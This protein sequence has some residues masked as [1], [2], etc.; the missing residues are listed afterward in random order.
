MTTDKFDT[1][2]QR[3][4]E[5]VSSIGSI[6]LSSKDR[7]EPAGQPMRNADDRTQSGSW[8]IHLSIFCAY[9]APPIALLLPL[10]SLN[11]SLIAVAIT[12]LGVALF[13]AFGLDR[14][15]RL[16]RRHRRRLI[17]LGATIGLVFLYSVVKPLLGF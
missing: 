5:S 1:K 15:D 13:A 4:L 14:A 6:R 12:G 10:P 7:I 17:I 11:G 8:I 3:G 2:Q 16:Q 9:F